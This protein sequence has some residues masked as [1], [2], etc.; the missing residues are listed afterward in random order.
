MNARWGVCGK[1]GKGSMKEAGRDLIDVCDELGLAYVNSLTKY[2]R[3][4]T[5]REKNPAM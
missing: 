4:G 5:I 1:Y 2:T 3:R